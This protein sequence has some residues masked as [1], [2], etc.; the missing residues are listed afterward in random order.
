MCGVSSGISAAF[1]SPIGGVLF[2]V[3]DLAA[4]WLVDG[5]L[6]L[7]CFVSSFFSQLVVAGA[8]ITRLMVQTARTAHRGEF[9]VRPAGECPTR[10][11]TPCHPSNEGSRCVG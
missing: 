5:H 1:N 11:S 6:V 10:H 3:E 4:R 8:H 2:V 9:Q 7:Q